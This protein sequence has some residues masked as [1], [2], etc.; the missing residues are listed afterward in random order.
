MLYCGLLKKFSLLP[1]VYVRDSCLKLMQIKN[2]HLNGQ[3]DF[4]KSCLMLRFTLSD[5]F[6]VLGI[7]FF[8]KMTILIFYSRYKTSFVERNHD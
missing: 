2:F 6:K 8:Y 7:M 4:V 1:S 5:N 3:K